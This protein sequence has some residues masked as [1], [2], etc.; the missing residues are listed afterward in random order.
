MSYHMNWLINYAPALVPLLD[1]G[2][3]LRQFFFMFKIASHF[4][5]T[6]LGLSIGK[7]F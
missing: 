4:A 6:N 1:R 2:P 3:M 7:K 5:D